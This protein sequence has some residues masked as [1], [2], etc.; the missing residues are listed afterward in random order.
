[1]RTPSKLSRSNNFRIAQSLQ[2]SLHPVGM[3]YQFLAV[4]Q[5]SRKLLAMRPT[6]PR[7]VSSRKLYITNVIL[8][9]QVVRMAKH[10]LCKTTDL[11]D[12]EGKTINVGGKALAVFHAGGSFYAIDN[13]CA[14][15]GGPLG[16]GYLDDKT[17]VCPWHGWRY[18]VTSGEAVGTPAKVNSYKVEVKGDQVFVEL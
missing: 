9:Y 7:R 2:K 14:H 16:E 8:P 18:D 12:G 11:G 5:A 6:R 1:M 3:P 10:A 15:R 17:V 4:S 13:T